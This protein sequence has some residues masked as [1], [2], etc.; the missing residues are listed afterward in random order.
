MLRKF[1]TSKVLTSFEDVMERL[2]S[3]SSEL[4]MGPANRK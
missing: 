2:I 3:C 4:M 1:A